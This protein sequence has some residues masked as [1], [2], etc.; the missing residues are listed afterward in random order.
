MPSRNFNSGGQSFERFRAAGL[1]AA[2]DLQRATRPLSRNKWALLP[3]TAV[4]PIISAGARD[5]QRGCPVIV[6]FVGAT[7]GD[8]EAAEFAWRVLVSICIRH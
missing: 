1:Q 3:C 8:R 6:N 5:D 4:G 2:H 7:S